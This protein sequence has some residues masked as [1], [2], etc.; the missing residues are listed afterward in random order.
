MAYITDKNLAVTKEAYYAI[1]A[2]K[3]RKSI[4]FYAAARFFQKN[5]GLVN[6]RLFILALQLQSASLSGF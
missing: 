6:L 3:M 2:A 4:G 1:L 5:T